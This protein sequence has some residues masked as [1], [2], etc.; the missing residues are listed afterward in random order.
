MRGEEIR[1]IA[2]IVSACT[3]WGLSG[4]YFG[5]I[6]TVPALE[7]LAHRVVWSVLFFMALFAMQGRLGE[8]ARLLGPSGP[9]GR[10][11]LGTLMISV[12]WFGY[13]WAVKNGHAT[14][15]SLGYYIFPL[16]A[17][18]LGYLAF[19]ER[20]SRPQ[21]LA[22]ALALS[23]VTVLTIWLGQPPWISLL[24]AGTFGFYGMIKKGLAAGPVISVGA[25]TVLLAPLAVGY[26]LWLHIAGTGA[27]HQGAGQVGYLMLSAIFTGMPLVLFSYASRRLRYATLGLVQYLNPTLQ[28]CVAM[29]YFAEP[30]GPAH[31]VAFPLIWAGVALYCYDLWRQDRA[32]RAARAAPP[33]TD[34]VR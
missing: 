31:A 14:E 26:L 9:R 10:I 8:L 7:I 6:D 29:L 23:A 5:R 28:F 15:A 17:V 13:V 18:V 30:F 21:M 16:V 20:F 2:A 19:G 11:A 4:L 1:G 25:E 3:I 27:F 33:A 12:N 32:L 34:P 22:I 24:L